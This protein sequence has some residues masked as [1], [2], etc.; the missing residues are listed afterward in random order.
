MDH[1]NKLFSFDVFIPS[2][3]LPCVKNLLIFNVN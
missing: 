3:S 2:D 1:P